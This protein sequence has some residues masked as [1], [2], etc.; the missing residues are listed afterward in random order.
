MLLILRRI[1]FLPLIFLLINYIYL[2]D[3]KNKNYLFR[4]LGSYLGVIGALYFVSFFIFSRF[5]YI[6]FISFKRNYFFQKYFES[7]GEVEI[8]HELQPDGLERHWHRLM[9]AHQ[10]RMSALESE[11]HRLERLQ[12]LAEKLHRLVNPSNVH[13]ITF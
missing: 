5:T 1:Q 13:S 10:D 11:V 9:M 6:L 3:L 4:S 7:I 2:Q 8:D 12:R